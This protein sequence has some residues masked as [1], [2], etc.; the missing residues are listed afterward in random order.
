MYEEYRTLTDSLSALLSCRKF[1]VGTDAGDWLVYYTEVTRALEALDVRI[2][3]GAGG[4]T[5]HL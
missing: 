1:A 2:Q 4:P 3:A 5:A